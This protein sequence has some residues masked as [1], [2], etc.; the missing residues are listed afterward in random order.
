IMM[1]SNE[2]LEEE[3][4]NT[5]Y[6]SEDEE[7][8]VSFN[9]ETIMGL[10]AILIT[11]SEEEV[12][13]INLYVEHF[14]PTATKEEIKTLFTNYGKVSQIKPEATYCKSY[15][16]SY[17]EQKEAEAAISALHGEY[18]FP[19]GSRP[20]IVILQKKTD[21]VPLLKCFENLKTYSEEVNEDIEQERMRSSM[22][23]VMGLETANSLSR[24]MSLLSAEREKREHVDLPITKFESGKLS[25]EE[26]G[27]SRSVVHK[28]V[29]GRLLPHA[30]GLRFESLRGGFPSR[31]ESM[32]FCPIDASIRGWQGYVLWNR[33]TNYYSRLA[34]TTFWCFLCKSWSP[35]LKRHYKVE[36]LGAILVNKPFE[37]HYRLD[38]M[39]VQLAN[40]I[41]AELVTIIIYRFIIEASTQGSHKLLIQNCFHL[42][43]LRCLVLYCGRLHRNGSLL[44]A[45]P[46]YCS[47]IDNKD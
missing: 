5:V 34:G 9:T 32:G 33:I 6:P 46:V 39:P 19:G 38:V 42:Q 8:E 30:R 24:I 12:A 3:L 44:L 27:R 17:A 47:S 43:L 22:K 18:T 14:S 35:R 45:L 40:M 2:Q 31:W 21:D 36:E 26:W 1:E 7:D 13:G 23:R 4:D 37:F 11:A 20:I 10:N 41:A 29:L 28:G 16:V 15:T 25:V